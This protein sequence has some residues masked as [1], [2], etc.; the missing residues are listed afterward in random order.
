MLRNVGSQCFLEF[1]IICEILEGGGKGGNALIDCGVGLVA[2]LE[3]APE[4]SEFVSFGDLGSGVEEG[5]SA[6]EDVEFAEL[7]GPVG[8]SILNIGLL[9]QHCG[10]LNA[11]SFLEQRT[12]P[13]DLLDLLGLEAL[14]EL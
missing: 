6:G 14:L 13:V 11:S 1:P 2:L 10:L 7:N 9:E 8:S 4:G 12:L 5:N 3:G